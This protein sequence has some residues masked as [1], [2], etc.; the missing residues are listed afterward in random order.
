MNM[1]FLQVLYSNVNIFK[2]LGYWSMFS[3][4]SYGDLS[5]KQKKHRLEKQ[6]YAIKVLKVS[7]S[8]NPGI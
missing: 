5:W 7:F 2:G 3:F 6:G 4:Q 8:T 1:G